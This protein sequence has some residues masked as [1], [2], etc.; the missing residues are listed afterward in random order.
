VKN[1]LID[2]GVKQA[3]ALAELYEVK[4]SSSRGDVYTAIGQ[5]LVHAS[6]P[7]CRQ[8]MVLPADEHLKADLS[9]ALER[10]GIDLIRYRLSEDD[11]TIVSR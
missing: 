7:K 9:A 11:V 1:V 6:G 5:L 2:L 8:V 10:N 4:T 3:G